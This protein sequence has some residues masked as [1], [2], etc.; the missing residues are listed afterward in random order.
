MKPQSFDYILLGFFLILLGFVI[1]RIVM[2]WK[3][4]AYLIDKIE[5]A[6]YELKLLKLP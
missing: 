2:R 6:N 3:F 1:Y 5:R 4:K